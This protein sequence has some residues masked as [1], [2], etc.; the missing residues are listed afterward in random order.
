M[1]CSVPLKNLCLGSH[2]VL[3]P[4]DDDMLVIAFQHNP[5]FIDLFWDGAPISKIT[6]YQTTHDI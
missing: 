5:T 3:T 1:V 4:A 6:S 2:V